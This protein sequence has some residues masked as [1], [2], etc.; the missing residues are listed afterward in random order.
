MMNTTELYKYQISGY[1]FAD[2]EGKR[3]EEY[4]Y[5]QNSIEAMK[6]VIGDIA[7]NESL[8]GRTFKLDF[9]HYECW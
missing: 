5:A 4:V 6:I 2:D 7:W 9:I 1:Y 3:F 8:E